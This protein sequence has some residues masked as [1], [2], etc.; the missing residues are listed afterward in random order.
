MS[1]N[2]F[3]DGEY[4]LAD[5]GEDTTLRAGAGARGATNTRQEIELLQ[6]MLVDRHEYGARGPAFGAAFDES[7]FSASVAAIA[8]TLGGEK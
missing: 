4:F 3:D 7:D 2:D 5:G 6:R 8:S 1:Y